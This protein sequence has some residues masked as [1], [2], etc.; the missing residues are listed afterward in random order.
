MGQPS[1]R[2]DFSSFAAILPPL[3]KLTSRQILSKIEDFK[4]RQVREWKEEDSKRKIWF[5]YRC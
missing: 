3:H 1:R 2:I 5:K 4:L